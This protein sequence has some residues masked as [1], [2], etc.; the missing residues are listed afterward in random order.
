M[1]VRVK[2]VRR[3]VSEKKKG[4]REAPRS[5]TQRD[6]VHRPY[7]EVTSEKERA[8]EGL[9][10]DRGLV[11]AHGVHKAKDERLGGLEHHF[12]DAAK[13]TARP[14]EGN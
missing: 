14:A 12:F 13:S 7:F 2:K 3:E 9:H 6:R 1:E 11:D 4:D 10:C 8:I 5:V